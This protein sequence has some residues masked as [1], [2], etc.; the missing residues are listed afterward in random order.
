MKKQ[1]GSKPI[2]NKRSAETKI[3][4]YGDEVTDSHNKEMPKILIDRKTL[5]ILVRQ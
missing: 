2:Y 4:S 1:L 3:K 5:I